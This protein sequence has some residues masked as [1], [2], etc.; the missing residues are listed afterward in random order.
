MLSYF[1]D[2]WRSAQLRARYQRLVQERV[3]DLIEG[4]GPL[5][6]SEDPGDWTPVGQHKQP[7]DPPQREHLRNVARRLVQTNPYARNLLRLLDVYVTGPGL[8]VNAVV[9]DADES[10]KLLMRDCDRLWSQ[11]LTANHSHFSYGETARR[12]W[13]DGEC[14]V[15]LFPQPVWPPV[16]RYLDPEMIGSDG[17]LA[18]DQGLLRNPRDAEEVLGYRVV[19]P[20]SGETQEIVPADEMRHVKI[21]A[22][23][24][25]PRGV[26]L[27]ASI[28][29]ALAS[30][31]KWLETELQA[32]KLQSSIV[33]WRKVH[34]SPSQ[35][36]SAVESAQ[37]A[38]Q[39]DPF[40]STRKERYRPGTILTTSHSTDLQF[41]SP[42]TN[43]GDAVPLGR[44]LLLSIAAG[45]GV[46]EFMLSS[47]A[48]N[49]NFASTMVAEGPA[50]KMFEHEQQFFTTEI[51]VLWRWV[52]QQAAELGLLPPDV[53]EQVSPRWTY[54]QLVNRE[55]A[56][57]R[58]A[59]VQLVAAGVLSRAEVAR[60]DDVDPAVMAAEIREELRAGRDANRETASGE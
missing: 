18:D 48:S 2:R 35:I 10:G 59:D 27:F 53:L 54:P 28:L 21:N 41:L 55:R 11:F 4:R 44:M 6:V 23:S 22:D 47:D 37:S 52:M 50:V 15:R 14:F 34:G 1:R 57:E 32:R 12:T 3:L 8:V 17:T 20:V 58:E 39:S 26:T 31:D 16:V 38:V 60:R 40:G 19:D 29:D 46:P 5:P 45:A 42:N 49:A 13:R 56:R 43:F 25:E 9:A 24:N 36:T 7:F 30:Y 33:L 51:S